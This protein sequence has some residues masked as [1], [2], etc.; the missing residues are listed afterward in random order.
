MNPAKN[1]WLRLLF[2][3]LFRIPS[4]YTCSIYA[5]HPVSLP[6]IPTHRLVS[7]ISA[8]QKIG[9]SIKRPSRDQLLWNINLVII[10]GSGCPFFEQILLTTQ[11]HVWQM[12]CAILK[13][14]HND[15]HHQNMYWLIQWLFQEQRSNPD[16]YIC[17]LIAIQPEIIQLTTILARNGSLLTD[18]TFKWH[19]NYIILGILYWLISI[20]REFLG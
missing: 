15:L 16:S 10:P 4:L 17:I 18:N 19:I 1:N 13:P 12:N 2:W 20:N 6:T 8:H 7:D 3:I 5:P 14:A 9:G 11:P